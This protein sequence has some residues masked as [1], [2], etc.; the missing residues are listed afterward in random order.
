VSKGGAFERRICRRISECW[1]PDADDCIFW[2][3]AGS[4]GR[5]TVRKRKGKA[6]AAAH[7]GDLAAIDER[8]ADL[9]RLITWELKA[10][11][12]RASLHALLDRPTSAAPQL[13]EEWIAQAIAAA[14]AART[15][16]WAI[17]H[18]KTRR[19]ITLVGPS[20]LFDDLEF[21]RGKVQPMMRLYL[22]SL[23]LTA[24]PFEQ[25]LAYVKPE[26]VQKVSRRFFVPGV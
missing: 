6:T 17:V 20:A 14:N 16:H 22:P 9:T 12:P 5:A 8:G 21:W 25:F 23:Q 13:Y 24:V 19:E 2:R 18:A 15:P 1:A 11:Y 3:T 26:F 7:C 10:G 4:G